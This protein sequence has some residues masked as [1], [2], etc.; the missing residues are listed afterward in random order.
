MQYP[1]A[2][3]GIRQIR[4]CV[5]KGQRMMSGRA[6]ERQWTG[7]GFRRVYVIGR[8]RGAGGFVLGTSGADRRD[9]VR[10]HGTQIRPG[11]EPHTTVIDGGL[12]KRDP[13]VH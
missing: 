6:S 3:I 5:M 10:Q 12:L 13:E 2:A 7:D 4:S 1:D 11:N 9:V 8:D